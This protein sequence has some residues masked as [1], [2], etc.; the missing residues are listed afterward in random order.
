MYQNKRIVAILLMGGSGMRF[1]SHLPKQFHRLSG[2]KI[3]LH[4][5]ELF[6]S[7]KEIDEV[8]IVCHKDW[9]DKVQKEVAN[10]RVVE[11]GKTRQE[12]AYL[13]LKATS[14][15]IVL[16]HDIVRPFVTKEV[17]LENIEKA[18][19]YSAVDTCMPSTD[20]LVHT[21]DQK[22]IASV[23]QRAQM[24]R[25]QTP[26][27]FSYPLIVAAHEH[28]LKTNNTSATDDCQLVLQYGHPVHIV[29]SDEYNL[30]ITSQLDLFIAEQILRM[31][32]VF[33]NKGTVSLK[34]KVFA[35][36]GG[37]GGIGRAIHQLLLEE[38]ATS[39]ILSPSSKDY[40][41]DLLHVDSIQKTF[42]N[43]HRIYPHVDGI[44]NCAGFLKVSPFEE[45]SL[46][47]IEKMISINFTGLIHVCRAAKIKKGGH[48]INIASSS[49]S[50]GRKNYGLYSATK[51]AVVNFTQALAQ[52]Q[53]DLNINVIIPARTNTK[54]RQDNFPNED[55]SS[56]LDPNEVALSIVSLLKQTS[57]TGS[58]LEVKK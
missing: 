50:L 19:R 34:E 31:R 15:D 44:I 23:P 52:E 43:L 41:I 18:H 46:M 17:I 1:S 10:I 53:K 8:L 9:I 28:A 58:I 48:I 5:V 56:L 42:D 29:L 30:K 26:Q 22:T 38:G 2:K 7:V 35:I 37:S 39:V 3:Y 24:L 36:V 51:A 12:S 13:G 4:T 32:K 47:E 25:G 21:K 33:L 20:T 54:M 16:L 55:P 57:V 40:P 45:L 14:A 6:K 11:G 27:S 49:Y